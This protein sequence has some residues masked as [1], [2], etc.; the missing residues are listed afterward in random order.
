MPAN[1]GKKHHMYKGGRS[2]GPS[3]R[4]QLGTELH[5]LVKATAAA[6]GVT[7]TDFIVEAIQEKIARQAAKD[8]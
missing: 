3:T 6:A 2:F 7:M 8:E 1:P 5:A 4:L